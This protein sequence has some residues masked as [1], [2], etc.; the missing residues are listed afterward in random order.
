MANCIYC[1]SEGPFAK[2]HVFP[3][4]LGGG[5]EGWT[6]IDTVC[7][8]CN[9]V[10][11][12]LERALA[13]QSIEAISRTFYGPIG[14]RSKNKRHLVS[15][16]S[17]DIYFLFKDSNLV[18]E[19]A[20]GLGFVPYLR[21]QIIEELIP[22]ITITG[23]DHSDMLKLIDR[24]KY[25]TENEFYIIVET[26][27]KKGELFQ[28]AQLKLDGSNVIVSDKLSSPL[29]KG[30]WFRTFAEGLDLSNKRITS[31][32]FMDDDNKLILRGKTFEDVTAF[33]PYLLKLIYNSQNL[34]DCILNIPKNMVQG[35]DTQVAAQVKVKL[36]LVSRAV[37]KIG[38]NFATKVYGSEY[39]T[40]PGFNEIKQFILGEIHNT[41][42]EAGL[43]VK[44]MGPDNDIFNQFRIPFSE[45]RHVMFLLFNSKS[46]HFGLKLYGGIGGYLARLGNVPT[47]VN[48]PG[49]QYAT[50]NYSERVIELVP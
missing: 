21:P 10:F 41:F 27:T 40:H 38:I 19:G 44:L 20:L 42:K 4:F 36:E 16:Y 46:L 15:L 6:L 13:R 37:A 47:P 50:V 5:G 3:Y 7:K 18:Y 43:H 9:N 1:N 28:L 14:R 49:I 29:P 25:F 30:A 32:T 26:P 11:S 8:D 2:E 45:D 34:N 22:A 31:R 48:K 24:V 39:T 35:I 12:S 17:E 23:S 33:L